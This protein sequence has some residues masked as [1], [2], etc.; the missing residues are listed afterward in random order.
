[1]LLLS[2]KMKQKKPKINRHLTWRPGFIIVFVT[3]IRQSHCGG[4]N[5]TNKTCP[6]DR[7]SWTGEITWAPHVA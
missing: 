2:E 5:G 1:M 6:V 4:G 3:E 7:V